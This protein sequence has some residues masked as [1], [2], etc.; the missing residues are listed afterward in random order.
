MI[1]IIIIMIIEIIIMECVELK[2]ISWLILLSSLQFSTKSHGVC[3]LFFEEEKKQVM[4]K[5]N[6]F[7]HFE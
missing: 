1:I 7:S 6:A 3:S 5:L 4:L 2:I